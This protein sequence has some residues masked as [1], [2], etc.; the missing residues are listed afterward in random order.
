MSRP[1]S[2]C[3]RKS[4]TSNGTAICFSSSRRRELREARQVR[5]RLEGTGT[6][7]GAVV[8]VIIEDGQGPIKLFRQQDA[9]QCMGQGEAGEPQLDRGGPLELRVQAVGTPDEK[10]N[11]PPAG[12][13]SR[14]KLREL[15]RRDVPAALR[16][17][18]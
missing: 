16:Q 13:P 4:S 10:G 9:N 17:R 6:G 8:R 14:E 7:L 15:G 3:S 18:R 2:P 1:R 12:E 5:G 11:V